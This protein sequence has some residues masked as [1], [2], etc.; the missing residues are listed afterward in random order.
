MGLFD[1]LKPKTNIR[2]FVSESRFNTNRDKQI[3]CSPQILEQLRELNVGVEKQLELEYFFYTNTI[4]K[5]K[6]LA[7]EIQKLNYSVNHSVSAWN[8]KLFVVMGWTTKMRMSEESIK[9]WTIQMCELGYKFDC[10]FDG[11]GT[12]PNQEK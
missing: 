3:Q 6:Q 10:E 9:Q 8:E 7:D 12:D 5:A 2:Q 11:W 1:F 4:E